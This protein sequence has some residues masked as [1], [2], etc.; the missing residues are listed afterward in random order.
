MSKRAIQQSSGAIEKDSIAVFVIPLSFDYGFVVFLDSACFIFVEDT[1]NSDVSLRWRRDWQQISDSVTFVTPSSNLAR[2]RSSLTGPGIGSRSGNMEREKENKRF[3]TQ[4]S[5]VFLQPGALPRNLPEKCQ[6]LLLS[7]SFLFPCLPERLYLA[8]ID[9]LCVKGH[10]I[11]DDSTRSNHG[12][13]AQYHSVGKTLM[14]TAFVPRICC[15]FLFFF[16]CEDWSSPCLWLPYV[17][18][19]HS[20]HTQF[21]NPTSLRIDWRSLWTLV[22]VLGEMRCYFIVFSLFGCLRLDLWVFDKYTLDYRFTLDQLKSPLF[23][24]ISYFKWLISG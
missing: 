16:A 23:L 22:F 11:E 15:C 1:V 18:G 3:L 2:V 6:Q 5:T 8:I 14:L 12:D 21:T 10:R 4:V 20:K 9:L 24:Y 19:K 13:W 7:A 17:E